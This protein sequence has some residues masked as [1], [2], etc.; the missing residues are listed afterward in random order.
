LRLR[1][2]ETVVVNNVSEDK[3]V[4]IAEASPLPKIWWSNTAFGLSFLIK[5]GWKM[6]VPSPGEVGVGGRMEE[7]PIPFFHPS[8]LP[9][10][11]QNGKKQA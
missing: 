4:S 8:S 5:K 9:F 10:S 2:S 1:K 6:E 11:R 7:N 3:I